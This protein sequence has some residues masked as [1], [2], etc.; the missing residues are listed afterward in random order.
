MILNPRPAVCDRNHKTKFA[1]FATLNSSMA[2]PN[3]LFVRACKGLPVERTPVWFMRQAGRYMAEYRAVRQKYS[4]VEICKKPKLPPR[5]P[6]P[7]PKLSKSTPPSSLPTSFCRSKSWAC[8]FTSRPAKARSSKSRFAKSNTSS[9]LRTDRA[10]DLG[11]VAESI[12]KVSD[13][14]GDKLPVIGFCGAPFTLASY[15]IEGGGSRNYIEVKKDDVQRARGLR[16]TARKLVAVLAEYTTA[17][18]QE[19]APMSSRSSTAGSA[20]SASKTIVAT[21]C[22]APRNS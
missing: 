8:P 14:F 2:A 19:P 15:M 9:A 1:H 13:H 10:A 17:A 22:R 6:S 11:Y 5:S 16:R 20:A 7:P 3:S 12:K 18:S 4:L 21:C